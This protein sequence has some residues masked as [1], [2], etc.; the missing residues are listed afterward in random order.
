MNDRNDSNPPPPNRSHD[1]PQDSSG[2]SSAD[3]ALELDVLIGRIVDGEASEHSRRRF[4][5][6]AM[7][8]ADLW[9][10]LALRQ[11]DMAMLAVH[12]EP[13][14]NK[15]EAIELPVAGS[16]TPAMVFPGGHGR[17]DRNVAPATIGA[18]ASRWPWW[19]AAS[20]W[21]AVIALAGVWAS[22]IWSGHANMRDGGANTLQTDARLVSTTPEEHLQKYMQAP[23]VMGDMS[24]TLLQVDSLPDGRYAVSY[25]RRIVEVKYYDSPEQ[26][27]LDADGNL[28]DSP[29]D[30]RKPARA[31]PAPTHPRD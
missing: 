21:A 12:V 28:T 5:T 10:R 27:P 26:I 24:P 1:L 11:Q 23:Y 31:G 30:V 20:G 2:D 8:D 4:E 14:L 15:A 29:R 13:A 3:V 19:L 22:S 6:L 7:R 25:L 18:G 9:R 16:E 17:P